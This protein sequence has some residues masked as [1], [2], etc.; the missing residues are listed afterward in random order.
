MFL[1]SLFLYLFG[2]CCGRNEISITIRCARQ[3]SNP[4][5]ISP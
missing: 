3:Q 5:K 2:D 1:L 4:L